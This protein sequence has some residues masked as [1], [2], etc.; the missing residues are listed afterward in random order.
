ME[1]EGRWRVRVRDAGIGLGGEECVC[2]SEGVEVEGKEGVRDGG[3]I[4]CRMKVCVCEEEECC[5]VSGVLC[6]VFGSFSPRDW[7]LYTAS[8]S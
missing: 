7:Q 4:Q 5:E 2:G 8:V 3:Y 1:G 6:D